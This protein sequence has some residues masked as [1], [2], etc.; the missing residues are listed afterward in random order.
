MAHFW[1]MDFLLAL[2]GHFKED[3][4]RLYSSHTLGL[5][6]KH[7]CHHVFIHNYVVFS[8]HL[9]IFVKSLVIVGSRVVGVRISGM[10]SVSLGD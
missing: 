8:R 6:N 5:C 7:N 3:A 1:K 10:L 4:K 2:V 9:M